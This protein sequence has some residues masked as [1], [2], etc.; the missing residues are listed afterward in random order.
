MKTLKIACAALALA[1]CSVTV[2]VQT[3]ESASLTWKIRSYSRYAVQVKFFSANR[4]HVWPSVSTA[5]TIRDYNVKY[6]TLGCISGEK[7][8]Y[9]AAIKGNYNIGW[10]KGIRGNRG[11]YNCCYVCGAGSTRIINLN[12]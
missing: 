6:F 1:M 10:G 5:Y 4:R 8:C 7:I 9:G 12:E 3:A 2:S 11:C